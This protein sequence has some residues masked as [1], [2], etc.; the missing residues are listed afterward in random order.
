MAPID[1]LVQSAAGQ[2]TRSGGRR[3]QRR[4][5][6]IN[7][8]AAITGTAQL[9]QQSLSE[10]PVLILTAIAAVYIPLGVLY[11]SYINPIIILSTLRLPVSGHCWR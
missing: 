2:I 11:E 8:P 3:D 6:R 9:F 5:A 10:E 4:I 7:M 1:H